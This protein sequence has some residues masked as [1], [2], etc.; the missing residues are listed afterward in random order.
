MTE[1]LHKAGFLRS[2][3]NDGNTHTHIQT[4]NSETGVFPYSW[5]PSYPARFRTLRESRLPLN[6]TANE[7]LT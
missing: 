4:I 7:K 2:E 3:I 5:L 6:Y 1:S